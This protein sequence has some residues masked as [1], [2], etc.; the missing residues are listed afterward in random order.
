[1]ENEQIE[2][3]L[4]S[5]SLLDHNEI[6]ADIRTD[7][8]LEQYRIYLYILNN[9][10][11]RR[12]KASE[13]F[14]GLNTA[15][16]GVLGYFETRDVPHQSAIFILVPLVGI[17][18]CYC[19]GQII[20]SYKQLNSAKFK[21]IHK[22]ERRLPI[23]LFETEWELLGRMKDKKKYYPLSHIEKKIPVIFICMYIVF[24]I[25]NLPWPAITLFF[26]K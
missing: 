2:S 9:T 25:I 24:S 21:V 5:D 20:N 16:I 18:I 22:L 26:T 15:I 8:F 7:Q 6:H 11:D 10:S 12:Q 14:L 13:F 3:L 17:G 4:F 23:A 19:W 1:M